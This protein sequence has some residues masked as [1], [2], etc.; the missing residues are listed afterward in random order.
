[1]PNLRNGSNGQHLRAVITGDSKEKLGDLNT[2]FLV[3]EKN[4]LLSFS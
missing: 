3:Q 4:I 1:M 2:F